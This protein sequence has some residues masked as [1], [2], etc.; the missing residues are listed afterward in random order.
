MSSLQHVE[1]DIV[2]NE[3]QQG[4]DRLIG[5]HLNYA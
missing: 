4:T 3:T 2:R 5:V 1:T